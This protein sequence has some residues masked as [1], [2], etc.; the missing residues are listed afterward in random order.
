MFFLA[1]VHNRLYHRLTEQQRIFETQNIRIC[2]G[3]STVPTHECCISGGRDN[4]AKRDKPM[5]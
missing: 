3:V 5:N 2:S 1:P 4:D